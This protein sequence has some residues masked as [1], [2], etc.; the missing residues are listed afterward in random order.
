MNGVIARGGD[1]GAKGLE[2]D[3]GFGEVG[4]G[5]VKGFYCVEGLSL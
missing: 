1:E 3:G 5:G 4:S 2:D